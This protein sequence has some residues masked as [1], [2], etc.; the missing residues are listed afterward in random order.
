MRWPGSITGKRRAPR[1]LR[2]Q[3]GG[4]RTGDVAVIA[5]LVAEDVFR[6]AAGEGDRVRRLDAHQRLGEEQRAAERIGRGI[7]NVI[8]GDR[9]R[10]GARSLRAARPRRASPGRSRC[11]G[12]RRRAA[13]PRRPASRR[14]V[15]AG[16]KPAAHREGRDAEKHAVVD[17]RELGGAAADVDME[18]AFLALP[19]KPAPRRR[20]GR[21]ARIRACGRRWRRRTCR[22]RRRTARRSLSHSALDRLAGEDHRATVD[23]LARKAGVAIALRDE[24]AERGGIDGAVGQERR[25]HD[26]RAPHHLAVDGDEAARQ[27]LALTLQQHL[28]EQ[29]VRGRAADVDADGGELDVLLAPDGARDLGTLLV[30]HREM[31]VKEVEFVH[32]VSAQPGLVAIR[33]AQCPQPTAAC[34]AHRERIGAWPRHGLPR[35]HRPAPRD[36]AIR[37]SP[38]LSMSAPRYSAASKIAVAPHLDRPV[39]P[40]DDSTRGD[41]RKP[42]RR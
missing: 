30:G 20:R 34:K 15:V 8:G 23:V 3:R 41:V 38:A 16:E 24:A 33:W 10:A 12:R 17:Q 5:V 42:M 32:E 36:R 9:R 1:E 7:E 37:V 19:G 21:R 14:R 27:A 35:L 29:E 31:L 11:R 40:G 28:G 13:P 22:P 18:H 39:E 2:A 25:E 4:E 26:R 6:Y